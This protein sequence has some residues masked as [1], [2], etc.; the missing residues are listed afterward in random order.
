M[1]DYNAALA[2]DPR[3]AS[4]LYVR[5]VL[6]RKAGDLAGG[7]ADMREAGKLNPEIAESFAPYGLTQ[8]N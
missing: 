6:K 3:R 1:T 5:G 7:N 2:I 4:S 8:A